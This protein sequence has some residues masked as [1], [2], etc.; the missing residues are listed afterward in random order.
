[1]AER[2][3][4]VSLIR[5][6]IESGARQQPACDVLE[7]SS[8]TYQRWIKTGVVSDGRIRAKR[9]TPVN[10]LSDDERQQILAVCNASAYGSECDPWGITWRSKEECVIHFLHEERLTLNLYFSFIII[11]KE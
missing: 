9:P 3:R 7:L 8:R 2:Q 4:V 6:A 11:I 10:K 1:M 5:E